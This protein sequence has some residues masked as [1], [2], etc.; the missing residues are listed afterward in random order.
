M[1][2]CRGTPRRACRTYRG[3]TILTSFHKGS[4]LSSSAS[5]Q[6]RNS[7]YSPIND[8]V[9]EGEPFDQDGCRV[10]NP[11][12]LH[13]EVGLEGGVEGRGSDTVKSE[14]E[15]SPVI[16]GDGDETGVVFGHTVAEVVG[17]VFEEE[18]VE[19]DGLGRGSDASLEH[20]VDVARGV[21]G[22]VAN[23]RLVRGRRRA[24]LLGH[25]ND[26]K[27]GSFGECGSQLIRHRGQTSL[28]H[29]GIGSRRL[30]LHRGWV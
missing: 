26:A 13:P 9:L 4:D 17:E 14:V 27:S 20:D 11:G 22:R 8:L 24:D 3:L 6:T 5:A 29:V 19:R 16:P 12:E 2:R 25:R 7:G 10:E 30:T 28:G 23:F 21:A 15:L 1:W 18:S